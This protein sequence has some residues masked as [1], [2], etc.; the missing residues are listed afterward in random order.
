MGLQVLMDFTR[1]RPPPGL[2]ALGEVTSVALIISPGR[3][4]AE[5]LGYSQV[6]SGRGR[7]RIPSSS[8]GGRIEGQLLILQ[9]VGQVLASL[10]QEPSGLAAQLVADGVV[11][12]QVAHSLL[13]AVQT[14]ISDLV[15][16]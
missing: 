9:S 13:A 11:T 10:V 8:T 12:V 7:H 6:T 15:Q 1:R 2:T 5:S 16:Q 3:I 4:T 14:V